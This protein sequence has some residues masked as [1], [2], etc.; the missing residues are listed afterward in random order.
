MVK[1][2]LAAVALTTGV[3]PIASAMPQSL[4]VK[5]VL[6]KQDGEWHPD[7]Y[8]HQT[9]GQCKRFRL[10]NIAAQ[11]WFAKAKEVDK[12]SWLEELDWTQ[13]S[14]SG[15]LVTDMGRTYRWELDQSGRARVFISQD[16][17]VYL[18][19]DPLPFAKALTST[20]QKP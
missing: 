2:L 13:C 14:A 6:V 5:S 10:S 16:V 9:V 4:R 18:S 20:R 12:H 17:E 19:G 8:G 1:H 7:P 15:T 3:A 11:R